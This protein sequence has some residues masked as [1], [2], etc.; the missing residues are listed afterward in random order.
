MKS[1]ATGLLFAV[2]RPSA[3]QMDDYY[4]GRAV[5]ELTGTALYRVNDLKSERGARRPEFRMVRIAG[6]AKS[7]QADVRRGLSQGQAISRSQALLRDLGNLPG[8]VCTPRYLAERA[9]L[10]AREHK[11][12]RVQ[13]FDEA[14][15][16][17]LKMN[18]LL[19]V[20]RGSAEPPRFIV[21]EYRGGA[22]GAARLFSWARV[23][24]SIPVAS[25]SRTRPPWM[26]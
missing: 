17:R 5:A 23:S 14:R 10:L 19:A 15:I 1:R 16:R 26:K 11:G 24:P 22:R 25:R 20:S 2:D 21:L 3:T 4:F 9:R 18:C 12:M 13:V 8:N 6:V 7:V